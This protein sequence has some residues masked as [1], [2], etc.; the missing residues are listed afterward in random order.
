MLNMD[1]FLTI[2][3]TGVNSKFKEVLEAFNEMHK[4]AQRL[5]ISNNKLRNDLKLHITLFFECIVECGGWWHATAFISCTWGL[6]QNAAKISKN[7]K[8]EN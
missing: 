2:E 7:L 5:A 8:K 4:E 1:D 3:E 6:R